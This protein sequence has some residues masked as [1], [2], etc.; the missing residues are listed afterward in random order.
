MAMQA[1]MSFQKIL[2]LAGL[3]NY[4]ISL[5]CCLYF[6]FNGKVSFFFLGYTGT[7]LIKD[8]KLPELLRELQVL[9][10]VYLFVLIFYCIFFIMSIYSGF[11]FSFFF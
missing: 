7:I 5:S 6:N 11:P 1:G 10:Q 3:G 9:V 4:L 8:G 2:M